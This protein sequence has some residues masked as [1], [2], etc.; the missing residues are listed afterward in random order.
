MYNDLLYYETMTPQ[1]TPAMT[2]SFFTVGYKFTE[3]YPKMENAYLR[4]YQGYTR[5]IFKVREC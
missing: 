1:D 3:D 2:W 5:D 4:S